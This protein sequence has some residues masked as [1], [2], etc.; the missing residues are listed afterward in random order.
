[1]S[2]VR[3]L[4]EVRE[5]DINEKNEFNAIPLFYACLCGHTGTYNT[6]TRLYNLHCTGGCIG[7]SVCEIHYD[8]TSSDTFLLTYL[9]DLVQYFLAKGAILEA[10]TFEGE[11]CYYAALTKEITTILRNYQGKFDLLDSIQL[12]FHER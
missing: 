8:T 3:Y 4:V 11:R 7:D 5:A 2:R 9:V 12:Y 10:G 6:Q 1:M